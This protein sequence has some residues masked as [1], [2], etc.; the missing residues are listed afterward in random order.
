M[1]SNHLPA[2]QELLA[3]ITASS[4]EWSSWTALLGLT[5]EEV[6][7]GEWD[8]IV[9]VP[10]E[11]VN[12]AA[13]LLHEATFHVPIR[14]ARSWVQHLLRATGDAGGP[15][16]FALTATSRAQDLDSLALLQAAAMQDHEA[17]R[18]T[19]AESG[20]HPDILVALAQLVAMP[21]LHSAAARLGSIKPAVWEHSYCPVCGALPA[22]AELRGLERTRA[23]RCGRCGT[24]W[25]IDRLRCAYCRS[26]D[27]RRLGSLVPEE[28]GEMRKVDTCRDCGG[29]IK[30][31]TTLRPWPPYRAPL[32]DLASVDLDLV[33][34]EHGFVRPDSGE[35]QPRVQLVEA[36]EKRRFFGL[37]G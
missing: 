13:P 23:L 37:R 12:P 4:P 28:G 11:R 33:A 27:Q 8:A 30:V 26:T 22:L 7:R 20:I 29:Y 36:P 18:A 34:L 5:L 21:L 6:A 19:A 31:L 25:A 3:D 32:E 35:F 2:A 10:G 15:D 24:D 9:L 1:A 14:L 17:L 16:A